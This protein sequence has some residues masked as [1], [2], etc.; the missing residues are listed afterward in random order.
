MF[1]SEFDRL[2]EDADDRVYSTMGVLV[3]VNDSEPV[4]AIYDESINEFDAMAGRKRQ[5]TFRRSDNVKVRKGDTIEFVVSGKRT[6][7][8]S[9][10]YP[11]NGDLM[12]VL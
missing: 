2:M 1:D 7:V 11:E 6:T 8:S 12:V 5:M 4:L 3:R 9:G 10:P